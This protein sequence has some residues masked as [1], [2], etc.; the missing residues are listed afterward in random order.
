MLIAAP[1]ETDQ[2]ETRVA[3]SPE[4]TKKFSALGAEVAI[5]RGAGDKA[6]FPDADYQSAGARLVSAGDA[7]GADVVLK[8]RRPTAH[9][10]ARLKPGA[11][12]IA[13]MD[14]YGHREGIEAMAKAQVAAFAM[15]LMPRIT[16]AQSMDVLSSPGQYRR[17]SRG[18]RRRRRIWPRPPDDDDA[19]RHGSG[20]ARLYHGRRRGGT[21]GH[22]H[23]RGGSARSSRRPTCVRPPR[24]RSSR[25]AR[26][27][28]RSKT[29]NSNRPRPRA[30]T[31]RKCPPNIKPRR[32]QLIGAHIAKQDI[33]ITT[34]LIP[35]RP[36]PQARF[37]R[38]GSHRCAPVR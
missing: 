10:A 13:T 22:R 38:A 36:A 5:E 19:G 35:G 8:V 6:G 28:S 15:E 21:A 7:L 2:G 32:R 34:A 37:G 27:S 23:R 31:P 24:S 3:A 33:V 20:G 30:A 14:P 17:L 9:E 11:L 26:S 16:R 29:T 25:S 12:V 1:A 4:T 18:D